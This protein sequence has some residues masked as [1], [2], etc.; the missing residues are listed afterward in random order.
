MALTITNNNG[1]VFSF[2]RSPPITRSSSALD[3]YSELYLSTDITAA[4]RRVV[5]AEQGWSNSGQ[6]IDSAGGSP[7]G[8]KRSDKYI[9]PKGTTAPYANGI[10]LVAGNMYY[11][12][13]IQEQGG[14]G[15][16][17]GVTFK[18]AGGA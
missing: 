2:H 3:D 17:A 8:Q 12:T 15:D 18:F 9:P 14:G 11:F 7:T 5:A 16:N 6:W 13:Y 4:N 1:L 10:P